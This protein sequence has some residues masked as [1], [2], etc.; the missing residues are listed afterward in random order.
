MG[1][2]S[3]VNEAAI[4]V[5]LEDGI[6]QHVGR[7]RKLKNRLNGHRASSHYSASYAFK[8]ARKALGLS[9]TYK[10]SGSREDLMREGSEFRLVFDRELEKVKQM[11][12]KFLLVP[13]AI[14]QYFLELYAAL[15]YNTCISEFDTH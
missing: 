15:E 8:R 11:Q 13:N 6:A 1:D 4:Y 2:K 7:T 14:D 9:A 12:V 3:I 10:K 5:L